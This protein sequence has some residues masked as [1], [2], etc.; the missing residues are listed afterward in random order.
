MIHVP[1]MVAALGFPVHI[2]TATS[3]FVLVF[4]AAAGSLTHA[5]SGTFA[6]GIGLRRAAALSVGVLG[7]AQLGAT[8]SRRTSGLAIRRVLGLALLAIALRVLAQ[9]V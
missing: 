6:S 7:G 2:A 8:L 5:L 4:M 1:L 3:H 9:A